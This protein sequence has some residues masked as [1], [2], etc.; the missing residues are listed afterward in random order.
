MHSSSIMC[1]IVGVADLLLFAHGVYIGRTDDA[2]A[3]G[4]SAIFCIV[5]AIIIAIMEEIQE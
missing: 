4:V 2:V 1:L 3:C 5:A